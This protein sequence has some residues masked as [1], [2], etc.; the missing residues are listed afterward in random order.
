[1]RI[2]STAIIAALGLSVAACGANTA[3][4]TLYSENQPVVKRSH[5][6]LDLNVNSGGA[7]TPSEQRR[8]EGWFEALELGYGDR[9]SIDDPAFL[10]GANAKSAVE[11]LTARYGLLTKEIAPPTAGNVPNG[12][13]RVVVSRSKAEVNKC[14]DFGHRTHTDFQNRTSAN[15]GCATNANLAAMIADPEDLV[16]GKSANG[17][18]Q[19]EASKAIRVFRDK[20]KSVGVTE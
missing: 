14:G 9:V 2:V 15:Y 6:V 20:A 3:N 19:A 7:L 18:D 8:L 17:T 1:M 5:Y 12:A 13:I 10:A 11:N 4:R 16:R